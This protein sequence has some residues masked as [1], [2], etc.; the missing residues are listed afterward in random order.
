MGFILR[1]WNISQ[2]PIIIQFE[3]L[4]ASQKVVLHH[5]SRLEFDLVL[6]K[7]IAYL[8]LLSF[9]LIKKFS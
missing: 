2:H 8:Y 9:I 3:F 5:I 6:L 7:F 4:G 1:A